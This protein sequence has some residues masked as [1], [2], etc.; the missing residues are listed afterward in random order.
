MRKV[1]RH[2]GDGG[3]CPHLV[4]VKENGKL[5][6]EEIR[7]LLGWYIEELRRIYGIH[8]KQII[9]YGSYARGDYRDDSDIDLMV[10]VDLPEG[11]MDCYADELSEVGFEYNICY[12]IWIMPVVKNKSHFQHWCD[13]YPF[14]NNVVKEGI[15]LYEAA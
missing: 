14:Y 5:A 4:Y 11:E 13:A 15:S 2:C 10:L 9:L 7:V 6:V 8:L 1:L 3:S 12:G